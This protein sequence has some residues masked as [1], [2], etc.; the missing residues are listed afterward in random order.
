M[1]SYLPEKQ[2]E[3]IQEVGGVIYTDLIANYRA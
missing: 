3:G 1:S 2:F